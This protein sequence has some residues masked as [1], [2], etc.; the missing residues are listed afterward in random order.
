MRGNQKYRLVPVLI[1]AFVL[2]L[3][4]LAYAQEDARQSQPNTI[5]VP[6][7][8]KMNIEGVVLSQQPDGMTLRSSGGAIYNVV[9][10]NGTEIKEKKSNP[11][12][13]AKKY[14]KMDLVP[15]LQVE[16]KGV[17]DNAGSIAANEL[18][19]RNDDFKVAQTMDTR[20]VPVESR[21]KDTQARLSET[22][23]NAQKLSG[24]VNELSAVSNAARGGAKAAQ[25]TADNAFTAANNA[26]SVADNARAGVHAANERI[27]SLDDYNVKETAVVHFRA[28]SSTLSR[29]DKSELERLAEQAKD[30]RGFLIE[31]AGFAS[32]D[33]DVAINRRLSQ[34]R[35]D[36]VIQFLAENYSI[37]M[38]RF[39]TPM[40]Y[41][42]TQ[43]VADNHTRNGRNENR[44]VEVRILVSK[45]LSNTETSPMSSSMTMPASNQQR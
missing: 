23:Q 5:Q 34:K 8:S 12:R 11:F 6:A 15:G 28:G 24:Q 14:S 3:T 22:E 29:E 38:R 42:E 30:E 44:R 25:E 26:R 4:M 45:G 31:V 21:L 2:S 33:G 17:G 18:R 39:V 41:G 40:G 20:V 19:L 10:A 43:P 1:A 27:T 9:V 36:A 16:V 13:G 35:A 37:P 32:S 7:G